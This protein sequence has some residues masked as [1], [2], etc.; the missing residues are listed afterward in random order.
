MINGDT[1]PTYEGARVRVRWLHSGDVP[2]LFEIFSDP[3][4]TAFWSSPPMP[5]V[6][7][8]ELLLAEIHRLFHRR[9]L[10]Q[11]GV[12]RTHD[13]KVIGTCT[14]AG[15]DPDNRRAEL[16]FALGSAHWGQGL[17]T[18]A[19]N[20]LVDAAFTGLNLHRLEADVDPGNTRSLALLER[21]G[22]LREGYLRERW[23]TLGEP[24]DTV[25]L[26]LLAREWAARRSEA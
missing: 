15:L 16:G 25:F 8:A 17:M 11:W 10:F 13:D 18:E 2:Q 21:F 6:A 23:L 24:R 4:V 1:L 5:G 26:G 7:D 14:L 20:L 3:V 22:F 9:E 19:L 12:A